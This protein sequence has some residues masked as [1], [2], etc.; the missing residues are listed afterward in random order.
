L[1]ANQLTESDSIMPPKKQLAALAAVIATTEKALA[2]AVA[3]AVVE[4]DSA[5]TAKPEDN[6]EGAVREYTFDELVEHGK[7]QEGAHKHTLPWSF[8]IYDFPVT[9]ET[10]DLYIIGT[11]PATRFARGDTFIVDETGDKV[12]ISHIPAFIDIEGE[13]VDVATIIQFVLQTTGMS[14]ELWSET[15]PKMRSDY[16]RMGAQLMREQAKKKRD[17]AAKALDCPEVTPTPDATAASITST[18]EAFTQLPST[19]KDQIAS[20]DYHPILTD[21][22]ETRVFAAHRPDL[23]AHS[24]VV[25]GADGRGSLCDFEFQHGPVKEVGVT[26]VQNEHLLAILIHRTTILNER[27][28]CDENVLALRYMKLAIN[29]FQSRT[30][31]RIQRGV[32]GT[33]TL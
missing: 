22:N 16:I 7:A 23:L 14:I 19:L 25:V 9:H 2:P 1:S 32:E 31:N 18:T 30:A 3:P 28:P 17:E 26:G 27:F 13:N 4:K 29:A 11:E 6:N 33:N 5:T 15:R 21:G 8:E 12:E 20:E 10:D 24:Y